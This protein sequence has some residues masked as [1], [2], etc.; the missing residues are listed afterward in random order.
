MESREE[1]ELKIERFA[2]FGV[3]GRSVGTAGRSLRQRARPVTA[4]RNPFP[5]HQWRSGSISLRDWM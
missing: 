3:F 2:M 4:T 1:A 5:P